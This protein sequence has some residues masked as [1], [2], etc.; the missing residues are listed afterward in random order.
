MHNNA[1]HNERQCI[2]CGDYFLVDVDD[3]TTEVCDLCER[4][5]DPNWDGMT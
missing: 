2:G 3:A 4:G 1:C 5:L